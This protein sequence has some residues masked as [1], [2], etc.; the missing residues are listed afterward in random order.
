MNKVV[1]AIHGGAGEDSDYIKQN[2]AAYEDGLK[3][4]V[5]AGYDILKQGGT[6]LDAVER[7]VNSLENNPLFNAGRGSAL[8]NHG[9][10]EMDAAIM[11]GEHVK[12]GAVCM[13][14]NVKNPVSLARKVLQETNHV[15][16]AGRGAMDLATAMNVSLETD[17]YFITDHQQEVFMEANDLESRQDLLRK[18]IHGTVGAVALDAG[19]NVASATS[20]GGIENSLPGR[21]G[22][23]C[24]IGAGCY[25]NNKTCA[26]STTGD[27]EYLITSVLAHS[28]SMATEFMEGGL[29]HIS[30]HIIHARNKNLGG[31]AGLISVNKNGEIGISFNSQ[32]MHRAWID[33]GGNVNVHIYPH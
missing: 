5:Q 4:A 13:V 7:A 2:K 20:T 28:L 24:I 32:R 3:A 9:E 30:D 26:V 1:I 23:S 19:G 21:V 14:K 6:A 11:D 12:A 17:A 10:V 16:I 33:A 8:N 18:K 31:N 25:A 27:G 15:L 22:D 29:Q